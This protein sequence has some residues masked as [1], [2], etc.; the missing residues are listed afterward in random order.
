VPLAKLIEDFR[1]R[2]DDLVDADLV[3]EELKA[4]L[5]DIDQHLGLIERLLA[6]FRIALDA[7]AGRD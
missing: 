4:L 3:D 7:I 1:R 5:A 6:D 2:V